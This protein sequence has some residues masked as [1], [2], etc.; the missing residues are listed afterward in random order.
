MLSVSNLPPSTE[1]ETRDAFMKRVEEF[2]AANP[3]IDVEPS[4]YEWDVATF[5]AQ[6]T[7][8][9]LPTVFQIPFPDTR[10]LVERGQVADITAQF[11]ALPYAE[12]FNPNVL[13]VA[14]DADG[15]VYGVPFAAYGIGLHYNRQLF[16][17]AGLD[18][19]QPPTTWAEVREAAKTI[20]DA[21]GQAGF[22]QLSQNNTGGWML[23]A[24]TVANGGRL[25]EGT[26]DDT[27]ATIDNP[28]T[29]KALELLR[30]MRWD[31]NSMGS[32]FLYEWGTIN[33][34]FAA[35]QIG[36]YMTGSDVYN[37]LVTE[38][39]VDPATYGL[40]ILPL[41]GADAGVLSGGSVAAIRADATDAEKEAG[42]KWID[43]F[44][45]EKLT[46]EAQAVADAEALA[47]SDAPIG[48]PALPIFDAE[49]LAQSDAW[50][51]D[52]VNVP[53]DQ[54]A[55][56]KDH[57]LEQPIVPEPAA[58][59]QEMYAILDSVVQTVL[60][61]EGADIPALLAE[62]EAQVTALIQGS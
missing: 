8:G 14:Q 54:M 45:M 20:A 57:I 43:F 6:M 23:T 4:E 48:T 41:D 27:A 17:E 19:D 59:T 28:G 61:D 26:G 39:E 49:Q 50:V 12:R 40:T 55:M 31:D 16:T 58:Q 42:V 36:M 44:Y 51:A 25:Q 15:K 47:A 22:A 9:T 21:T 56:F 24:L 33:Q 32:N 11:E 7:G 37:S 62:A 5:A 35:G 3:D 52:Y 2:E 34:A 46:D 1:Q 38:N 18:P 30:S 13:A 60:T 10:G 53:L 29:V